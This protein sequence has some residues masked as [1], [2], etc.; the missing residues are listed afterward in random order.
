MLATIIPTAV[1]ADNDETIPEVNDQDLQDAMEIFIRMS[2]EEREETIKNLMAAVE[3][4]PHGKK[5]METLIKMLPEMNEDGNLKFMVQEDEI[6]K[7][8]QA[9]QQ[10]LH[11]QTWESFWSMQAQILESTLAS[12]QISPQDAA[13]FKTDEDAWKAQMRV[14]W[15]DLQV[16]KQT[17]PGQEL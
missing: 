10:Q 9:A 2:K 12:G 5:E 4:D 15:D 17:Q 6:Q 3:N 7:A 11:G 13:R 16:Q 8:K 14:I 1:N